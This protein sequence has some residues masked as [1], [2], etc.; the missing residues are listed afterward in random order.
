MK[1]FFTALSSVLYFMVYFPPYVL[2]CYNCVLL[3][4]TSYLILYSTIN[5]VP[6]HRTVQFSTLY[7]TANISR[8]FAILGTVKGKGGARGPGRRS[9]GPKCWS[10][11]GSRRPDAEKVHALSPCFRYDMIHKMY[12][13]RTCVDS[14]YGTVKT[15]RLSGAVHH[16]DQ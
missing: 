2:Y 9:P 6:V 12:A 10:P 11:A 15:L 4:Q 3:W 8:L 5:C 13:D 1:T 16:R 14:T 7:S